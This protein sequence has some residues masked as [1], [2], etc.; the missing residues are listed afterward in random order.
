M[1]DAET[2]TCR[3]IRSGETY[4]GKQGFDYRAGVSAET[5]GAVGICMHLLTIPPGGRAKAHMHASHE[6]AVYA[7]E[8]ETVMVMWYGPRLEQQMTVRAGDML[9]IPAGMPHLPANV[10]DRPAMAVIAHRPQRAGKRC[11]AARTRGVRP[12]LTFARRVSQVAGAASRGVKPPAAS[13]CIS[14]WRSWKASRVLRC[15]IETTVA[16]GSRARKTS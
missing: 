7:I 9:Y 5:T 13:G 6:T 11:A 15:P 3:V 2:L 16:S 1:S 12:R 8:G 10:S 4:H 14:R